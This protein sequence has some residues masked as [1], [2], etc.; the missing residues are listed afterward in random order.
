M[1]INPKNLLQYGDT[2][3]TKLDLKKSLGKLYAPSAKEP[4]LVIAPR[5]QILAIDGAGDPNNSLEYSSAVETLYGLSYTIRFAWKALGTEYS[6]M[7]LE[8]FWWV[9][10]GSYER[11]APR[12][13]W[14]WRIFIVQPD[15][16]TEADL[17]AAQQSLAKKKPD[18][19]PHDA[20][21]DAIEEGLV[22]QLM[23]IG[24][25]S[26]EWP[27]IERLHH[28]IEGQGMRPRGLHHEVYLS[29]PRRVAPEKLKT[30]LRHAVEPATEDAA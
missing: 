3:A 19:R 26:A 2:M 28:F 24:P 12:D 10:D 11:D 17:A 20:R 6:V 22:A 23:H 15:F 18:L 30:I 14:R 27:N 21:L 4:S 9:A 13:N 1:F 8:G 5:L 7:P 25:Y 16:V 29:D